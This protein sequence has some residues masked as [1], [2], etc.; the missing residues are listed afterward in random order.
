[1]ENALV[2]VCKDSVT[3]KLHKFKS[4]TKAHRLSSK[5]IALKV[6]CNKQDIV[7]YTQSQGAHKTAAHLNDAIGNVSISEVASIKKS[8]LT[9]K[10]QQEGVFRA[11]VA[12]AGSGERARKIKRYANNNQKMLLKMN[13]FS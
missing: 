8:T 4:T 7:S 11:D 6:S 9:L 5:T 3:K 12:N 10:D 2:N 1:M 13:R